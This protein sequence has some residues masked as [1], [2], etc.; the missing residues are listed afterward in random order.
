MDFLI[1]VGKIVQTLEEVQE[2]IIFSIKVVQLTM[3]NMIQDQLLNQLHK[4]STMQ[5]A[6]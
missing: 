6:L 1:L 3:A 4:V 2:Q 5:H